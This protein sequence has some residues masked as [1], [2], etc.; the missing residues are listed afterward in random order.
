ML[1]IILLAV[2]GICFVAILVF[3]F[4]MSTSTNSH[5]GESA[6][7]NKSGFQPMRKL[8]EAE[9]DKNKQKLRERLIHAGLYKQNSAGYYY[10]TQF[11]IAIIPL[12]LCL[13]GY[14][15]GLLPFNS[16]V[17]L[18]L[19]S[20]IMG[21][22]G[23]GLWL[24]YKK[25]KR[26]MIIRRSIPDALD[27]IT[28]CVEAGLSLN[29]AIVRVSRD[30]QSTYPLLATELIIVH[31]QVQMGKSSGEALRSFAERFDL[32]ELRTLASVVAQSQKLGASVADALRSHGET[33]RTKRM[34]RAQERAQQAAVKILLPTVFCI[35]PALFVVILGPAAYDIQEILQNVGN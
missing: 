26:Q 25:S 29:S 1:P 2:A 9:E 7:P 15:M 3:V 31:R 8:A 35:F 10:F 5:G 21:V 22:I 27:V 13:V 24:D 34:Q 33:M 6:S 17:L 19:V 32:A 28:I 4:S 23:P 30:L 16:A 18:G 11:T 12:A 14:R 20:G